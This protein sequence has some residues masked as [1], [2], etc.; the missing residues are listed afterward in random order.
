M[1]SNYRKIYE[2]HFGKIPKDEFGR[3]YQIHHIDGNHNNNDISNLKCVSIQEHYDIHYSQGDWGACYL[4]G[5]KMKM[6][7]SVLSELVRQ[8]QYSRI[9]SGTHNWLGQ[10]NPVHKKVANGTHNFLKENR[11]HE[12]WNK[13]KTKETD[14]RVMKNAES[15]SKV[16]YTEETKKSFMKPKSEEGKANMRLGQ[17]GKKYP[18][19]PCLCCSKEIPSNAM[20]SHMR[21]HKGTN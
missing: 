7:V 9:A 19:V 6:S 10:N 20:A 8:Q 14:A 13:G 1:Q 4:I 15:R 2:Q 16:R 18:K 12:V 3:S 11:T 17:L 5:R 21:T